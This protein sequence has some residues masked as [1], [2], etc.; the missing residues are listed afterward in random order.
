MRRLLLVMF[1]VRLFASQPDDP[2][3]PQPPAA[4]SAPAPT[5]PPAQTPAA[6]PAPAAA[7]A[8]PSPAAGDSTQSDSTQNDSTEAGA[9]AADSNSNISGS[10]DIGYRY[11]TDVAGSNDAY[12]SVVN[13][14]SGVKVFGADLV[15]IDP[16]HQ[17]FDRLEVHGTNWWDPYNTIRASMSLKNVYALTVDYRDINYF[18]FLP[19]WADITAGQG[20]YLNQQSFD[21]QQRSFDSELDLFPGHVVQPFFAAGHYSNNGTGV[22]D[23]VVYS[24]EYALPYNSHYG[25]NDFRAGV[26]FAL[27][28][29]HIT[30]EGGGTTYKDEDDLE[31]SGATFPGNRTT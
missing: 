21:M 6:T 14:G 13:L 9:P 17:L 20:I 19:S 27:P 16:N 26:R 3:A 10:I 25:T 31:Y 28:R 24:N 4:T 7:A 22:S 5:A 23:Y 2:G 12:R 15:L 11:R 1:C 8:K 18:N 29:W 30:L